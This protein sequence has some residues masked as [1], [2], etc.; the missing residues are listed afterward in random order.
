[1]N[2]LYI[3]FFEE[4]VVCFFLNFLFAS[5]FFLKRNSLIGLFF[6][7]AY[8]FE[9]IYKFLPGK[10]LNGTNYGNYF[11]TLAMEHRIFMSTLENLKAMH[12]TLESYTEFLALKTFRKIQISAKLTKL[13]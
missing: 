10:T 5:L 8:L 12:C 4:S 2:K 7:Q 1:M 9:G 6:Y 11:E 13:K 3:S